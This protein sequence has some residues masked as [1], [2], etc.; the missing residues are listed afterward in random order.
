MPLHIVLNMYDNER[1][2]AL[3]RLDGHSWRRIVDTA[4]PSPRDIVSPAYEGAI[5]SDEVC[6]QARSVVVLEA[7]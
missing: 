2:V 3:P 6:V 1:H 4:L 5:E 7:D